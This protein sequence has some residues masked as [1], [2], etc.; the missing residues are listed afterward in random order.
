[1]VRPISRSLASLC[2]FKDAKFPS[3]KFTASVLAVGGVTYST[4]AVCDGGQ[5]N[6]LYPPI[7]PYK[8][9]SIAVSDLHTVYYEVYGNPK[10]KPVL[11]IHGGPGG[12]TTPKVFVLSAVSTSLTIF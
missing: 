4:A 10:G 7:Q 11:F 12:G 1:M 9:A 3:I 5:S 6:P 8:T 2:K